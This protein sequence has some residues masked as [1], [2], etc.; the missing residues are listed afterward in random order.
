MTTSHDLIVIGGGAAGLGAS[1]MGASLGARTLMIERDRLGGDCTWTG[2]IPSKTL[3]HVARLAHSARE[4]AAFGLAETNGQVDFAAI[5]RHVHRIRDNVYDDA[6]RPEIYQQ[7]G[8][9]TL[10]GQASFMDEH[11]VKVETPEGVSVLRG[12]RI[13]IASG[14]R[15]VVPAIPG[16][17]DV[18]YLT[19]ETLF[20]R[21][22]L[23]RR[24]VI[25]GGGPIGIEM[26][27][28]FRRLG[29]D[30]TVVDT[31][32]RILE[33]DD[34]EL[35]S[36]LE[37]CLGEEGVRFVLGTEVDRVERH[38]D[39]VTV[40]ITTGDEPEHMVADAILLASGRQPNIEA[41]GLENARVE[42]DASGITVD[43]R[44]RTNVSHIFAAGDVTG[45]FQ[46]TH[47]SEHMA[48]VAV[49]NALLRVPAKIDVKHVPW[50]TYTD[51]ELAHVGATEAMLQ[52][53][54]A[55]FGVYRF[56]YTRLDR[57]ITDGAST[58]LIKVF[59]K[60]WN[61][62]IL[63]ASILGAHA[64]EMI[65]ELA[66]AMRHGITLRQISDTIHP[67]PTYGLGVRRAADQWYIQKQSK[68]LVRLLQR[69]FRFR[70]EAQGWEPGTIR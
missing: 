52:S 18:P 22:E 58:G 39:A 57:A 23:P 3:L 56:P 14:S 59:A 5:A 51:P 36:M 43:D 20:E 40:H 26:A 7:M 41:L 70:G 64:G 12:R 19:T 35:A 1:G 34:E 4:A 21:T 50:V 65:G 16:I 45:R 9:E 48:K 38:D 63:G 60:R 15:P 54:G 2:C 25:I 28:A 27:Q 31:L 55:T 17:A 24:L 37:Q 62:K 42:F 66:L 53:D 67:Y 49:T 29:S 8:V 69:V 32:D 47:M 61:G 11:T 44:C 33:N 30:V 46:F 68:R 13:I 10:F 6:D